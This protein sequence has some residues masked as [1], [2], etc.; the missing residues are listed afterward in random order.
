MKTCACCKIE[1]E[2]T[3]FR[4][5]KQQ[6]SG[7]FPYCKDCSRIKKMESSRRM[8][9][10]PRS[11][12]E[13]YIPETKVCSRCKTE[14]HNSLF[15]KKYEK[16]PKT[17]VPFYYLNNTCKACDCEIQKIHYEKKKNDLAFKESNRTRAKQYAIVNKDVI[18][19][20]NKSRRQTPEHKEMMRKY[21]EKNREKIMGQEVITKNRY[22]T[23][24]RDG[25][26]DLYISR[27]LISNGDATKE[28][29]E[30]YPEIIQAKR[31]QIL[32]TRKINNNAN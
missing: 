25:L 23:K 17:K 22:H 28:S 30:Q 29:L 10:K 21:R 13:N 16:R 27:L 11:R 15:N 14:K 24:H 7:L 1:K 19:Q 4:P 9:V 20:Q 5:S 8:G 3:E 18:K 32:L 6:K 12:K 31:L 26:T 2:Y